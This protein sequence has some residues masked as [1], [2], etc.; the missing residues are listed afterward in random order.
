MKRLHEQQL[1]DEA[2]ADFAAE[3]E[4]LSKI[5]HPH[6]LSCFGACTEPQNLMI[7]TELMCVEL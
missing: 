6:I 3:V 7:V 2:L 4:I 5:H 1:T